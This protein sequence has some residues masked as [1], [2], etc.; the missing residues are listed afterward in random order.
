MN[1]TL[2]KTVNIKKMLATAIAGLGLVG[3]MM[4]PLVANADTTATTTATVTIAPGALSVA[5]NQNKTAI[6]AT[7]SLD[8]TGSN[9][10]GTANAGTLGLTDARGTGAGYTVTAQATQLSD[11]A[12]HK[13]STGN[14]NLNNV[15]V[16]KADTTSGTVPTS[17]V[18][19]S[20]VVDGT[21]ATLATSKA[22]TTTGTG[23]GSYSV[24]LNSLNFA[25]NAPASAYAGTYSSTVTYTVGSGPEN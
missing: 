14:L 25:G 11:A 22:D 13:L 7:K 23:M 2:G 4:V 6:S 15:G 18:A 16:T 9:Y 1:N 8:G 10:T 5:A 19:S 24:N 12:G 21:S 3:S 20:T 17:A